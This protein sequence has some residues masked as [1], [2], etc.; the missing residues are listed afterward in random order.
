MLYKFESVIK[1]LTIFALVVFFILPGSAVDSGNPLA[2]LVIAFPYL[3]ILV[4]TQ[5]VKHKSSYFK[6]FEMKF[7]AVFLLL[8]TVCACSSSPT[9]A[10]KSECGEI[11]Y[12]NTADKVYTD[13]RAFDSCIN[14]YQVKNQNVQAKKGT[15]FL[16]D[17]LL[18][19]F[20]GEDI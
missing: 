18:T 6:G 7:V 5:F 11:A 8:L 20:G 2:F 10:Q 3:V 19:V 12:K 4:L 15:I 9:A 17:V 16:F 14:S 1:L 13:T